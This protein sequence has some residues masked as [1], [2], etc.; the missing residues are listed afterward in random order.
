M[1][2]A[3]TTAH[4]PNVV[5]EV[6]SEQHVR[7]YAISQEE[8]QRIEKWYSSP[9]ITEDYV[10]KLNDAAHGVRVV[11]LDKKILEVSAVKLNPSRVISRS[12]QYLLLSK[13]PAGARFMIPLVLSILIWSILGVLSL[14]REEF[15]L[16]VS[17]SRLT[18]LTFLL[19][20]LILAGL[21]AFRT[22][23]LLK[24]KCEAFT[25][26]PDGRITDTFLFNVALLLL[27]MMIQPHTIVQWF[28]SF[29]Q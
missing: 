9:D 1:A 21:A 26:E 22:L 14:F 10:L 25:F 15:D 17:A 20:L 3:L 11:R 28:L 16:I 27:F 8:W 13:I 12:L 29:L 18:F 24:D 6:Q 23:A 7:R 19:F 2:N 4:V 5:M